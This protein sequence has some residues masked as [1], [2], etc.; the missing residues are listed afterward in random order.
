MK[1]NIIVHRIKRYVQKFKN[2]RK[3][4]ALKNAN[5]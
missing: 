4:G 5:Y 2:L 3:A 1:N